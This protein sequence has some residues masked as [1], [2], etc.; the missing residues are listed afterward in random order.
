MVPGKYGHVLMV[1]VATGKDLGHEQ[2]L[3]T[4][5]DLRALH[6]SS[7]T[8]PFPLAWHVATA[9]IEKGTHSNRG[10]ML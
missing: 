5:G 7:D 9:R 1:K 4:G 6:P 3:R 8:Y 2:Q 10:G